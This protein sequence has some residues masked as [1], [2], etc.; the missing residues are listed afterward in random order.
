MQIH[1]TPIRPGSSRLPTATGGISRL[2]CAQ[3]LD[4]GIDVAPILAR[5][6]ISPRQ[7]DDTAAPISVRSQID[8]LNAIADAVDDDLLGFHLAR[9]CDFRSMGLYFYVLASSETLIDALNRLARYTAIANEGISQSCV[10]GDRVG[11]SYKYVGVSRHSDRHQIEFWMTALVRI[12]RQ[13][14]DRQLVPEA[15]RFIHRRS[16]TPELVEYFGDGIDFGAESDEVLFAGGVRDLPL[17]TA[18]PYLNKLLI[19]YC[20]EAIADRDGRRGAF[21]PTVENVVAPLLPH[22]KAQ[23]GEVARRIGVSQRTLARRLSE[24]GTTFSDLLDDLRSNLAE[25]YLADD[26]LAI[27]Q[28]AWL[29]G[30]REVASFS[31]AFKRWTGKTPRQMRAVSVAHPSM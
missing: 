11:V 7:I 2:A 30:Y 4:A 1:Q 31:H 22:G 27:S 9:S 23:A 21:R 13:L 19:S 29:L 3:A 15:V 8:F 14:T 5:A 20:E 18:D 26:H 10:D 16:K 17:V 25:R 6:G 28:I 12:A 24:E